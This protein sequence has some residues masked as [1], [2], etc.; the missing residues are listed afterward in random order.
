MINNK[1]ISDGKIIANAFNNYFVNVGC[2]L[3]KNILTETDPLHYI[4]SLENSIYIPEIYYMDEVRTIISAITNSASGN[5]ELPASILKQC[6]DLYLEPLTHLI[7][8]NILLAKLKQHGIRGNTHR[9]FESYLSNRKQ[10]V[11]Y[12]NFKSDTKTITHGVPQ[13]SILGPLLILINNNIG[14]HINNTKFLGVIID[15]KLN[16]A[17]H[18]LYIKSKISKS[19]GI[20]LKIRKFI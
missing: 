10:Y 5:D 7:N 8:N 3:A 9:W 12:N 15:S 19:S 4:E 2:S 20:L 16:C 17:A 13:G 6:T 14:D 11:E 1:Y 18:I